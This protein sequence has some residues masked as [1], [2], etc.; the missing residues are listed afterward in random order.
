[1]LENIIE[2]VPEIN[3]GEWPIVALLLFVIILCAGGF[4]KF[5]QSQQKFQKDQMTEMLQFQERLSREWQA[6]IREQQK[7]VTDIAVALAELTKRIETGFISLED[8][9]EAHDE[10]VERRVSQAE[11]PGRERRRD[12]I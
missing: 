3:W 6:L 5:Y 1:V 2:Y 11:Y 9:L 7:P 8:K 4:W 12:L 10:R